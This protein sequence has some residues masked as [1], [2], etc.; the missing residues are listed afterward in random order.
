VTF[1][2]L[3]VLDQ[4]HLCPF[5]KSTKFNL[6]RWTGEGW[7]CELSSTL[8]YSRSARATA[9]Q[10]RSMA[11]GPHLDETDQMLQRT[12]VRYLRLSEL[13]DYWPGEDSC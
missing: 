13:L 2:G 11:D 4:E 5:P 10:R 9:R 1:A 8:D 3:G 6:V 7:E 12:W